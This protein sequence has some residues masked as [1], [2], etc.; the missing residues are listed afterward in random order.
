MDHARQRVNGSALLIAVIMSFVVAGLAAVFLAVVNVRQL[1]T[2]KMHDQRKAISLAE[3]AIN[4]YVSGLNQGTIAAPASEDPPASWPPAGAVSFGGGTY[5]VTTQNTGNEILVTGRGEYLDTVQTIQSVVN[6]GTQ[7][8]LPGSAG[9]LN[10]F[11]QLDANDLK[12]TLKE[13]KKKK[14]PKKFYNGSILI[15]GGESAPGIS[16]QDTAAFNGPVPLQ[17]AEDIHTGMLSEDAIQGNPATTFYVDKGDPVDVSIVNE[18]NLKHNAELWKSFAEA[19]EAKVQDEYIPLA[20]FTIGKKEFGGP[21]GPESLTFGTPDDPK[22]VVFDEELHMHKGTTITGYGT[23]V[24]TG[25]THI[26]QDAVINWNGNIIVAGDQN[27]MGIMGDAALHLHQGTL[28]VT[29]G[30]LFVNGGKKKSKVHLHDGVINVDG[31]FAILSSTADKADAK[32]N[33]GDFN[34]NGAFVMMGEDQ[35]KLHTKVD[36]PG[37]AEEQSGFTVVGAAFL[38]VFGPQKKKAKVDLKI[39]GGTEFIYDEEL[40]NKAMNQMEDFLGEIGGDEGPASYRIVQ[41]YRNAT[42]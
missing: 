32:I 37:G 29:G 19:L 41:V 40:L 14:N 18:P 16:I 7:P 15:D 28:N 23:L 20:D 9:A 2:R 34:I 42:P 11:G 17:I 27:K 25:K 35:V 21:N 31:T 26:H 6:L 8:L 10:I 13:G 38:G 33:K 36:T 24:I 12:I 1:Q 39:R 30:G 22:V 5:S 4:E 3:S